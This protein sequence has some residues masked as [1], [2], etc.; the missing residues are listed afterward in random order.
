MG[1]YQESISCHVT[2][3]HILLI[4]QLSPGAS[5]WY[6]GRYRSDRGKETKNYSF[7]VFSLQN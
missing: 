4:R 6:Y 7:H 2:E 3:T 1:V 5:G